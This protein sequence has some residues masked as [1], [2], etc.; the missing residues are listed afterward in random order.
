MHYLL[1]FISI[2]EPIREIAGECGIEFSDEKTFVIDRF[3]YDTNDNGKNTLIAVDTDNLLNNNLI[4][5]KAKTGAPFLYRGIGMTADPENPLLL[6]ILHA[7]STSF[8][9]A[10]DE[11]VSDVS[12]LF[13]CALTVFVVICCFSFSFRPNMLLSIHIRLARTHC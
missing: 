12:M 9:Y 13:F 7:A 5:G 6:S 1:L 8:T 4:A 2:A 11:N 10:L 3:N